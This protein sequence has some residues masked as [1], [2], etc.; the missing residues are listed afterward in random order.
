MENTIG[1]FTDKP[2]MMES[3]VERRRECDNPRYLGEFEG[4]HFMSGTYYTDKHGTCVLIIG[5]DPKTNID[6][7]II[8]D[9]GNRMEDTS[10]IEE[11]LIDEPIN[12]E[13]LDFKNFLK[14][15]KVRARKES[16]Q[17]DRYMD[18]Y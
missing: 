2:Q 8:R 9:Y 3:L 1:R 12:F 14:K 11:A 16:G 15:F 13:S 5:Y 6:R 10:G 17:M 4:V 18:R 7:G